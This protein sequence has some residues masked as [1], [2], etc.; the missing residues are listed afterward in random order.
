V[1]KHL[2]TILK[3]L[4][5]L[6]IGASI[7]YFFF[8]KQ[9][10]AYNEQC[11]LHP[12]SCVYKSLSEKLIADFKSVNLWWL[13][14]TLLAF[15]F[16][17]YSR[18]IRGNMLLKPLG[19]TPS[20]INGFLSVNI[21]YLSNLFLIRGGEVVRA[22]TFSRYEKMSVGQVMGTIIADRIL[23]LFSLAIIVG[24][25]FFIEFDILWGFI[26]KN[27]KVDG[28]NHTDGLWSVPLAI[29][30]MF[31]FVILLSALWYFREKIFQTKLVQKLLSVAK[32]LWQ[33]LQSVRKIDRPWLFLLHSINIWFMYYLMTYFC[34]FAFAPTAHLPPIA[35]LTVFVFGTFGIVIPSPGGMG[36]YHVLATAALIVHGIN[37]NDAFSFA[38]IMF[39]TVQIF[40]SLVIGSISA[41]LISRL[42]KK[43]K[44]LSAEE[45][46]E[47]ETE[48]VIE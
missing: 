21:S 38:N 30:I 44:M 1:K 14:M 15:S 20:V 37:G 32:K 3:F 16:S 8:N 29:G 6:G 35:A 33:G 31:F 34:F 27:K 7:L 40:Y 48:K 2:S 5:F 10:A 26:Q 46:F 39:F 9:N 43:S 41:L 47:P 24:F 25:S 18:A 11:V 17:N 19:Y 4:L 36:S 12:E 22:A 13:L 28:V 42:N 45:I 23:D